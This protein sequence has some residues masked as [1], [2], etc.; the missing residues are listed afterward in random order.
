MRRT[1]QNQRRI[2]SSSS[3]FVSIVVPVYNGEAYIEEALRS[4]LAQSFADWEIIVVDGGSRDR[5]LEIIGRYRD[6]IAT[7]ISEPDTGQSDAL[8][9]GFEVA[10]GKFLTWLNSDDI[11]L[12]NA[13]SRLH[14]ATGRNPNAHWFAGN[15]IWTT[16]DNK[17][18]QC[19]KGERWLTWLPLMGILNAYGPSTFFS[20]TLYDKVEGIREELHF[21]MDTDLW[22]QFFRAGESVIRLSGYTWT[23]RLHPLAK[24]S[25]HLFPDSAQADAEHSSWSLKKKEIGDIQKRYQLKQSGLRTYSGR[26]LLLIVRCLSPGYLRSLYDTYA[27]RGKPL[28]VLFPHENL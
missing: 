25:G 23:L 1:P 22:W 18:R 12:P 27:Y 6:F 16:P 19:R 4:V 7:L 9:K 10:R 17:I 8:R 14:D 24:M 5:T 26:F 2:F 13:L 15:V 21:M 28:R 20:R 11:L 3:P